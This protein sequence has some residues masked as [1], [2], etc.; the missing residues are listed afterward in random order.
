M[1]TG[2]SWRAVWNVPDTE[3]LD[4]WIRR[5][6]LRTRNLLSNP[7]TWNAVRRLA[8]ALMEKDAIPGKEATEII[9]DGFNEGVYAQHPEIREQ[10]LALATGLKS[11]QS[12]VRNRLRRS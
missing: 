7:D 2:P 10:E 8:E 11:S 4:A 12:K 3:E 5:L 9:R 1:L 6:H